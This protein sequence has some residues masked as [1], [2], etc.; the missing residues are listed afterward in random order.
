MCYGLVF[1]PGI[2]VFGHSVI[3]VVRAQFLIDY[4]SPSLC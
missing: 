3:F 1:L 4:K 2:A